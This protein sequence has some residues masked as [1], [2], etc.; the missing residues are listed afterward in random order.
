MSVFS[1]IFKKHDPIFLNMQILIFETVYFQGEQII[2]L[3]NNTNLL[4]YWT[5]YKLYWITR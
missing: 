4:E 1:K 3:W 5:P 2:S